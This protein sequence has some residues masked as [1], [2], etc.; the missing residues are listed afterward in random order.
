[1]LESFDIVVDVGERLI[2][3]IIQWHRLRIEVRT[4][5]YILPLLFFSINFYFFL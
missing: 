5:I 2:I 1:M 4:K 3:I